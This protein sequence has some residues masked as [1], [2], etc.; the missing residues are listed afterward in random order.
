MI[1]DRR[2][3]RLTSR[4]RRARYAGAF[5][6]PAGEPSIGVEAAISVRFASAHPARQAESG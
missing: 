2:C 3:P 4:Y 1:D 6:K 5:A